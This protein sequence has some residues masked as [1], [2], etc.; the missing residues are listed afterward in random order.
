MWR[1]L[2]AAGWTAAKRHL[3]LQQVDLTKAR[4]ATETS[5]SCVHR[6]REWSL[7][8]WY[9]WR[10]LSSKEKAT[11]P[12]VEKGIIEWVQGAWTNAITVFPGE[13][14]A[15]DAR[16]PWKRGL[17][18]DPRLFMKL[19]RCP[20]HSCETPVSEGRTQ[21]LDLDNQC[22]YYYGDYF[23]GIYKFRNA[24]FTVFFTIV[25]LVVEVVLDNL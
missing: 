11:P 12:A 14:R 24:R 20:A 16:D 3:L 1:L 17:L 6:D 22:E 9:G 2:K 19:R 15:R 18:P 5:P 10:T 8:Q 25:S 21:V 7:A 4:W 23:A 13:R